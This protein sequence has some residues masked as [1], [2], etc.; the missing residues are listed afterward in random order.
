MSVFSFCFKFKLP[1]TS[2]VHWEKFLQRETLHV[3][4]NGDV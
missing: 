2:K 3:I 1:D 4:T